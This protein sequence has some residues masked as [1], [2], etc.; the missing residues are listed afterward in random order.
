MSVMKIGWLPVLNAMVE[1]RQAQ[2]I[3]ES[4]AQNAMELGD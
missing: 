2:E 4:D 1:A 3:Q